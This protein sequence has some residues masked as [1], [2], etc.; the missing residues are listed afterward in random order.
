MRQYYV[1]TQN[2]VAPEVL[3]FIRLHSLLYELHLN[4]IRFWLEEGPVLTEFL[5]RYST[6]CPRLE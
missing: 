3:D 6:Q 1:L 2:P 4:R 5:L